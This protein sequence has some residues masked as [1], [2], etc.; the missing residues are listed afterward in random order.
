MDHLSLISH[1]MDA[2]HNFS[3]PCK[4]ISEH[5][6]IASATATSQDHSQK[7]GIPW[8]IW[9][10]SCASLRLPEK[11]HASKMFTAHKIHGRP[12]DPESASLK[13]LTNS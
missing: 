2:I 13:R 10:N 8:L 1:Q 4:Q 3:E 5:E 12:L 7:Q 11:H 9:D 6:L